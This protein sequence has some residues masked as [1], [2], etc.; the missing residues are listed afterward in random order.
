MS[1]FAT[2][3]SP[4]GLISVFDKLKY[5]HMFYFYGNNLA[6]S[7]ITVCFKFITGHYDN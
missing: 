5:K 4:L 3:E 6:E 7:G 2:L 1:S